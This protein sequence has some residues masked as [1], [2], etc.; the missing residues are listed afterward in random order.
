MPNGSAPT[1][2]GIA[3]V[4]SAPGQPS[5]VQAGPVV[6]DRPPRPGPS[7]TLLEQLRHIVGNSN[8]L[9]GEAVSA[10]ATHFWD[11]SPLVAA[12]VLR[13]GSTDEV[14]RALR[15]CHQAGQVVVT[16]GGVTGLV[17]GERST[18]SDVVLSLERMRE[19]ESL[20][21]VGRTARVQ[22]GCVLRA[23]QEAAQEAGLKFGLDLGARGSATIGGNIATNA[24]GL[25]VLRYGMM[26]EQ[27]LGLEVVLADGTVISSLNAMLKNNAGYDLKHWFIG[28]EGTLGVV[29]RAVLRLRAPTPIRQTALVGFDEF[30]GVTRLLAHLDQALDGT[31]DAFEVLWQPFYRLNTDPEHASAVA[32]PL[33]REHPIYAIV[34]SRHGDHGSSEEAER[35]QSALETALEASM[36]VDAAIAQSERERQTIWR[37]RET[38][39]IA[40]EH[41]PVHVYDVSLP[42]VAMEDFLVDVETQVREVWTDAHFYAY[43]HLADGNLHL[44]VAPGTTADDHPADGHTVCDRI[45]YEAIGKLGGSLSAE[46]GIGLSK[47]AWLPTSRSA[48]EIEL[49]RTL[50]QSLDPR[51]ILNPGKIF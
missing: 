39:E 13:P 8:V 24:G 33:T 10:R 14:S 7:N 43:G 41:D 22:A 5:T 37:I 1:S 23:V 15:A 11:P 32:A 12:A 20:D 25:S 46:H 9:T 44:M 28:S 17:G 21:P 42:I 51:G 40:L 16:H 18:G 3:V 4:G 47:K 2:D 6:D 27:V 30:R 31:L 26:R 36:I 38:I 49:M 29:T 34:E 50:K 48:A 19:I 45:V 35:L